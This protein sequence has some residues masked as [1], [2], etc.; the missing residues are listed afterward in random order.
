MSAR[1]VGGA[2][3]REA[4]A[5]H[6]RH[7]NQ[8]DRDGLQREIEQLRRENEQLRERLAERDRQ[9]TQDLKKIADLE[10]QMAAYRKDS[11]NSSM[12]PSTDLKRGS[13]RRYPPR[14]KSKRKPGGQRG[15]AGNIVRWRLRI[16]SIGW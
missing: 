16:V 5:T 8:P 13:Q 3:R 7:L 2:T 11:T 6:R 9:R 14:E 12:P 10:R 1:T 15:H 4:A